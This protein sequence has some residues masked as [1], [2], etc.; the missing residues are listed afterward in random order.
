[1]RVLFIGKDI[2]PSRGELLSL[3]Q[4]QPDID[5]HYVTY[6][7]FYNPQQSMYNFPFERLAGMTFN[8]PFVMDGHVHITTNII[9]KVKEF[10]PNCVV[11]IGFGSFSTIIVQLWCKKNGIP[12]LIWNENRI[13]QERQRNTIFWYIKRMM[14]KNADLLIATGSSAESHYNE[15]LPG[16]RCYKVPYTVDIETFQKRALDERQNR[17]RLRKKLGIPENAQLVLTVSRLD[18]FKRIGDI[19]HATALAIKNIPNIHLAIVGEGKDRQHLEDEAKDL[20]IKDHVHFLGWYTKE[21]MPCAYGMADIF[22]LASQRDVW[23]VVVNEAMA[24]GL[25]VIASDQVGA[26][27]DL[28]K[29]GITGFIFPVGD[30]AKLAELIQATFESP[31]GLSQM[32]HNA[33]EL[34]CSQ[35]SHP[36]GVRKLRGAINKALSQSGTRG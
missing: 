32:G 21:Q 22:V 26:A 34:V 1:M 31:D 9:K 8:I 24:S 29:Q 5:I 23:G 10:S 18:P 27:H 28:V 33:M 13:D 11:S 20:G 15:L 25:P 2:V 36:A 16:S 17:A 30:R 3:F 7:N 12:F 4:Q 14:M 35:Y 6:F 19:M